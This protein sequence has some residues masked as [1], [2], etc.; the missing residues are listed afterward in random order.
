MKI[1]IVQKNNDYSVEYE[2]G[3][4]FEVEGTWYGGVHISGRSGVPVSL[5]KNEYVELEEIE[6]PKALTI[7]SISQ[8]FSVCKVEDFSGV[9]LDDQ[10][11]F[12]GKT[13]QEKSVVCLT[14]NVPDN[15]TDRED[16]WKAF[17]IVGTLD[18]SLVGILSKITAI[19]AE[20]S[21][22]IFAI[23]TYNT[24][25]VLTKKENFEKAIEVLSQAGYKTV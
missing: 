20:N 11:C 15:T 14:E 3:D 6:V 22:G 21:I 13:D 24:D 12:I 23:S 9:N 10:Y 17:R 19:L 8:D 7:Q 16:G 25:Y 2:V 1:K 4:T 5:D 18:F